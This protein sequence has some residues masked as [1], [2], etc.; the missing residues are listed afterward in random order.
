MKTESPEQFPKDELAVL[1][2]TVV[3]SLQ[4]VYAKYLELGP[5][6]NREVLRKPDGSNALV[7]N[8]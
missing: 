5:E 8:W 6:G 2:S 3:Q 7:M 1:E 4:S